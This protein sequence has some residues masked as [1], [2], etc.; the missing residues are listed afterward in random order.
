MPQK[1]QEGYVLA[2]EPRC[3]LKRPQHSIG[4]ALVASEWARLENQLIGAF[5]FAMFAMQGTSET[6]GK[7]ANAAWHS[8]DS[9]PARLKLLTNISRDTL[10][11]AE[12]DEWQTVQS[13]IRARADER[14]RIVH[15]LWAL[16][17]KYPDDI[18]L[19][20]FRPDDRRVYTVKDFDQICQRILDT[21]NNIAK[22][23][24][25][26]ELTRPPGFQPP[27]RELRRQ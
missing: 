16:C 27:E 2:R 5:S 14:N 23:W 21:S 3:L 4:I 20:T 18:V 25:R 7:M 15:G 13:N 1:L 9:L 26:V 24:L 17:E 10:T 11:Q 6:S 22:F 19:D 8:L 12:R